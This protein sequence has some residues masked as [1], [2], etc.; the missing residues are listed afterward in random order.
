[1]NTVAEAPADAKRVRI[2]RLLPYLA[3]FQA[4]VRQTLH[5]W[6]YRTW[7]LL[8]LVVAFGYLLYRFG[9]YHEAQIY[10]SASHLM[11]DLLR[12]T[13]LGSI[14]LIII[15]TAGSI[16]SELGTLA[17][18]VL[19][20]GI[21]RHQYFLGKWHARLIT[22]LVTF[23]L[24]GLLVL[25]GSVF[26]LR[27]RDISLTGSLV[28][29]GT[30]A[31][32][33]LVVITCGVTI[34]ALCSSTVLGIAAVWLALYGVS[35]CLSLMPASWPSPDRALAG[36][37]ATLCGRYDPEAVK[38]LVFTCLGTSFVVAL[39]GLFSFSRRDV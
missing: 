19:S 12:W 6:V 3:V 22:V 28:A 36:L 4:D 39:F 34:S 26:L 24:L 29:L 33:L 38:R 2:N 5:S 25:A 16:S 35:F 14:T 11:S 30:V 15:L 20:R 17:D 37:S 10:P 1:M 23:F 27:D 32:L 7:V 13:T 18:S 31:A 9:A 8:S 21:S